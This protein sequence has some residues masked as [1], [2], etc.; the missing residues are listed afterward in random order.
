MSMCRDG[1]GKSLGGNFPAST[2]CSHHKNGAYPAG[3]ALL[4][5]DFEIPVS[6]SLPA[7]ARPAVHE[8][9]RHLRHVPCDAQP[10]LADQLPE[11]K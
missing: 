10:K 6:T 7:R 5:P 3:R 9:I 11:L 8:Q 2:D 4:Q 1:K